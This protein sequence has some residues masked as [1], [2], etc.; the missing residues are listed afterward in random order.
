[1]ILFRTDTKST[2]R[3]TNDAKDLK[4]LIGFKCLSDNEKE[5][6][7]ANFPLATSRLEYTQCLVV[8]MIF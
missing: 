5:V 7:I 4:D 3:G 2:Q 1:M 6:G 8:R